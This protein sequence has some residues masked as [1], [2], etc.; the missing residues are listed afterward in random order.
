MLNILSMLL[1]VMLPCGHEIGVL[2]EIEETF[3]YEHLL[4]VEFEVGFLR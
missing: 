1:P 3:K 2:G 4:V